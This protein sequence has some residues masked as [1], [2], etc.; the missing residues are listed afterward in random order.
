M[1]GPLL[2]SAGSTIF[3]GPRRAGRRQW[4]GF[5]ELDP[6]FSTEA[7][8]GLRVL[9]HSA[10]CLSI[11]SASQTT[12]CDTVGFVG[13][14]CLVFFDLRSCQS[15]RGRGK[16]SLGVLVF[17]SRGLLRPPAPHLASSTNLGSSGN[18]LLCFSWRLFFLSDARRRC[19][20]RLS[21]VLHTTVCLLRS[22]PSLA[23]R[24]YL[25]PQS[26]DLFEVSLPFARIVPLLF[27]PT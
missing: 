20:R 15:Q 14:V 19:V 1:L 5:L 21:F 9:V 23:S 11:R 3:S 24:S 10:V 17:S 8:D 16:P 13:L 4:S 25:P 18:F 2:G 12:P 22:L 6:R 26:E 7:S 27:A